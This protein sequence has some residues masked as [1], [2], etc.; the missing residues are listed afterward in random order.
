MSQ[1]TRLATDS[2]YAEYEVDQ[3]DESINTLV[4]NTNN[5]YTEHGQRIAA[6]PFAGYWLMVDVDRGLHYLL[7]LPADIQQDR[8]S[9]MHSY[10]NNS[11]APIHE[12]QDGFADVRLGLEQLAYSAPTIDIAG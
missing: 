6:T 9:I 3:S 8:H 4:F 5:P 7:N 11:T 2:D 12:Y 10:S 1:Y